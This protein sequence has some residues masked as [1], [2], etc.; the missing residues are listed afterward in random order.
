MLKYKYNIILMI[1]VVF[2]VE[3]ITT[4]DNITTILYFYVATINV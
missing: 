2:H 1:L 4:S 3:G